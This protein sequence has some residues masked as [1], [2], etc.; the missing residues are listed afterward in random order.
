MKNRHLTASSIALAAV[1]TCFNANAGLVDLSIVGASTTFNGATYTSATPP[2]T[3]SGVIGSFVRIDNNNDIVQGYNTTVNDVYDTGSDDIFNRAITVGEIG[4]ID[5]EGVKVMRFMLD[6]N[7]NQSP[8]G[9]QLNLDEVQLYLSRTPNQAVEDS[10]IQA[11]TID[12]INSTLVY[13]MDSGLDNNGVTLNS[14]NS[15]G[16]G[17]ADMFLDIPLSA[18]EAAFGLGGFATADAQNGAY[19]YLYSRFGSAP[20]ENNAGYEEWAAIKGAPLVELPCDPRI[21]DCDGQDIPEPA[22]LALLGIGLAG[23]AVI[24]R[25]RRKA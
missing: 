6:I 25:R 18:F 10:L 21:D 5:I 1:A 23:A 9:R 4:F 15:H 12:F 16:S 19:I 8:N 14:G 17:S 3:G 20:N 24:S 2:P 22:S 11:E 13:Q 7:Q